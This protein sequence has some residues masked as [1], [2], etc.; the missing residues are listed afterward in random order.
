[1][2]AAIGLRHPASASCLERH[3]RLA[4]RCPNNSSLFP[5]LAAVVVVALCAYSAELDFY[6]GF[7]KA[8]G[9]F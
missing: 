3:L 6:S 1:M 7:R 9:L 4:G 8:C 5:P 2:R